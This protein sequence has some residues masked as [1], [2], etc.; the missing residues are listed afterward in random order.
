MRVVSECRLVTVVVVAVATS[1]LAALQD[2]GQRV[3]QLRQLEDLAV[4]QLQ[5]RAQALA[6]GFPLL[7]AALQTLLQIA[8]AG[9]QRLVP[10]LGFLK[11]TTSQAVVRLFSDSLNV[12]L[13]TIYYL[14][15]Y[16]R[17]KQLDQTHKLFLLKYFKCSLFSLLIILQ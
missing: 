17:L 11:P 7:Q 12:V 5:Q 3:P 8:E 2:L 10:R 1:P 6:E 13:Y 9:L 14:L 16:L 4:Q 15:V